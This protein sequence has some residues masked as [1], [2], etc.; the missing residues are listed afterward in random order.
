MQRL[1]TGAGYW[2]IISALATLLSTIRTEGYARAG[3]S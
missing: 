2:D 1:D 3:L